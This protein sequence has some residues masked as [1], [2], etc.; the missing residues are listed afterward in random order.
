MSSGQGSNS[1][2]QNSKLK[3]Q[4]LKLKNRKT[5]KPKTKTEKQKKVAGNLFGVLSAEKKRGPPEVP[6]VFFHM[7]P[8][9][10]NTKTP[11]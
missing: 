8:L 10:G 6:P 4:N 1:K 5:G 2:T 9:R 3:T 7:K 11:F